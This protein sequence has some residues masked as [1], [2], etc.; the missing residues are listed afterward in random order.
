MDA[1]LTS[2]RRFRHGTAAR[3]PPAHEPGGQG[4]AL[5]RHWFRNFDD[6]FWP[7]DDLLVVTRHAIF[8]GSL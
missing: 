4:I 5:V 3:A 1:C 6:H 7:L 2:R 8:C